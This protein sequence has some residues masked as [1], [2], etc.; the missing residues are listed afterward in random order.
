[1]KWVIKKIS[2]YVYYVRELSNFSHTLIK[3][4]FHAIFW[5]YLSKLLYLRWWQLFVIYSYYIKLQD[6]VRSRVTLF[7]Y[8]NGHVFS[9]KSRNTK[10]AKATYEKL[11]YSI[12][13]E[14]HSDSSPAVAQ[15]PGPSVWEKLYRLFNVRVSNEYRI[16]LSVDV[17]H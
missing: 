9:L 13:P 6:N 5:F 2:Q 10:V 15:T 7:W 11:T 3:T 16:V 4:T 1:M 12:V 8:Y 14:Q 17:F